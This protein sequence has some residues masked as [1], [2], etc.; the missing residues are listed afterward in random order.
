VLDK[1]G[2]VTTGTMSVL[3]VEPE[4][5]ELLRL[6]AAVESASAHPIARAIAD[7]PRRSG[8]VERSQGSHFV[9]DYAPSGPTVSGFEDL[10]GRGARGWVEGR[11]VLVGR[12]SL[13]GSLPDGVRRSVAE[14]TDGTPVVVGWDGAARGVIVVADTVKPTSVEAVARLKGL[15]LRPVLLTGDN[16]RTARAIADE[17]GIDEVIA[18]SSGLLAIQPASITA[19]GRRAP[20]EPRH[21]RTGR[22]GESTEGQLLELHGRMVGDLIDVSPFG[23][24]LDID[25]GSGPIQIF[26]F[27]GAGISTAGLTADVAIHATCFSNQFEAIFE[28]DPP[29]AADFTVE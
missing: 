13:F 11:E 27:P 10:S 29:T 24:K 1:T 17:V 14:A 15:G 22:V 6:A 9:G 25:D 5:P 18:D 20:I 21:H 28:C 19:L 2:T 12:P 23:F 3:R 26:L 16:A 8:G 7:S 4:D